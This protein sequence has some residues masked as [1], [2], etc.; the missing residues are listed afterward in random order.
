MDLDLD[1]CLLDLPVDLDRCLYERDLFDCDL[2]RFSHLFYASN[3]ES[4]ID[5]I[6]T[7]LDLDLLNVINMCGDSGGV[8]DLGT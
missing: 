7:D 5:S 3:L 8:G 4:L 2:D 6:D 1:R